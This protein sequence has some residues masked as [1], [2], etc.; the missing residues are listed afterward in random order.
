MLVTVRLDT[1]TLECRPSPN[2]YRVEAGSTVRKVLDNHMFKAS[3]TLRGKVGFN[4][5]SDAIDTH[6]SGQEDL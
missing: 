1:D 2:L 5:N 3:L 4:S 6:N